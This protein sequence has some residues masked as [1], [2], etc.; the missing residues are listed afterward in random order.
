MDAIKVNTPSELTI[1]LLDKDQRA[2]HG[3]TISI[4]FWRMAK[5]TDD[6]KVNFIEASEGLYKAQVRLQDKGL[7]A[8]TLEI[9]NGGQKYSG[10]QSI[11]VETN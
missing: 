4:Q 11:S 1:R 7:W 9:E 2:I 10:K 5:S 6:V 3:A 8:T